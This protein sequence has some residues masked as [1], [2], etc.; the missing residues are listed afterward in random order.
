[1]ESLL[2]DVSTRIVIYIY[3]VIIYI[4]WQIYTPLTKFRN[5]FWC[6]RRCILRIWYTHRSYLKK[7]M[8]KTK[9]VKSQLLGDQSPK[10]EMTRPGNFVCNIIVSRAMSQEHHVQATSQLRP[11]HSFFDKKSSS[12]CHGSDCHFQKVWFH[13]PSYPLLSLFEDASKVLARHVDLLLPWSENS[14]FWRS[15]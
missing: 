11:F 15:C 10:R 2:K 13:D 1:M 5:A 8:K 3:R 4:R 6:K 9:Q 12:I 7:Q 14:A